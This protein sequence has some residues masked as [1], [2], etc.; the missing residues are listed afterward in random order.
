MTVT[1]INV[2]DYFTN[3][4]IEQDKKLTVMQALKLT[5][6]AQ[7]FHLALTEECFFEEKIEA[8]QYGPVVK[9]LYE[10]LR[11]IKDS[12]GH[13]ISKKTSGKFGVL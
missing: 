10:H 9:G 3:K 1:A 5:Y 2:S 7:G 4:A 11:K 12:E 8:W 6:I 13:T